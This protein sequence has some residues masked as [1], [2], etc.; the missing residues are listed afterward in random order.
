[1]LGQILGPIRIGFRRFA[2]WELLSG[3]GGTVDHRERSLVLTNSDLRGDI[4]L[5]SVKIVLSC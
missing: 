5:Y 1:M 3:D 2:C 4:I